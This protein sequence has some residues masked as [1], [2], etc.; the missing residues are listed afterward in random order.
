MLGIEKVHLTHNEEW[1]G[2]LD[3]QSSAAM[4]STIGMVPVFRLLCK[5]WNF[6]F[7]EKPLPNYW[8]FGY[9]GD[10]STKLFKE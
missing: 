8:Y 3:C 4:Y 1:S 9:G 10:Y 5:S 2:S 6:H 7:L